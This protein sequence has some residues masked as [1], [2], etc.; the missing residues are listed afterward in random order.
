[1]SEPRTAATVSIVIPTLDAGDMLLACLESFDAGRDDLEVILVDNASTDDSVERSLA[2][3]PRIR[4]VRNETNRGYA[5]PCNIGASLA[6][7]EFVLF[8]NNDAAIAPD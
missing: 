6:T 3:F 7:S 8:L 1:M 4:V 5:T 2:R